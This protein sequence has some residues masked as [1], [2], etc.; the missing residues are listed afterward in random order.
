[1]QSKSNS[2]K[3]RSSLLREDLLITSLGQ[4]PLIVLLRISGQDLEENNSNQ[5]ITVIND[6]MNHEIRN[7]EI[8]WS[9]HPNWTSIASEVTKVIKDIK[10]G[11]ASIT[12]VSSLELISE[13]G[14]SYAMCPFLDKEMVEKSQVLGQLLIPGVFSPSDIQA[15]IQLNCKIVKLFPASTLGLNYISQLKVPFDCIPFIIAAGGL[16]AKDIEP[17]LSAGH[18]AIVLGKGLYQKNAIDPL[19]KRWLKKN[20]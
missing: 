9:S 1:L 4:Q 7:I 20:C 13:I 3:T 18:N 17:W 14:F 15:A 2:K 12:N 6:L 10:F 19:L 5:I 16:K 8:A 11:A